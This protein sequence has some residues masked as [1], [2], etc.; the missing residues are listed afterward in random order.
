MTELTDFLVWILKQH[1]AGKIPIQRVQ[2]IGY[3][4]FQFLKE[5]EEKEVEAGT[6]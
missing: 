6:V 5:R 2:V 1:K 4:V 3:E